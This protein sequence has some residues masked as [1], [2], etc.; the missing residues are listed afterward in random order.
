MW[1]TLNSYT[2]TIKFTNSIPNY[3]LKSMKRII[4][5]KNTIQWKVQILLHYQYMLQK[6]QNSSSLPNYVLEVCVC[7]CVFFTGVRTCARTRVSVVLCWGRKGA[8]AWAG[9]W[10]SS[11]FERGEK[12]S[13]NVSSNLVFFAKFLFEGATMKK[14]C[15]SWGVLGIS[16]TSPSLRAS[17]PFSREAPFQNA[18]SPGMTSS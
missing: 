18:A 16:L 9:D 4:S 1:P 11:L 15:G 6:L 10:C 8:L 2:S 14:G 13:I 17:F 7:V 5:F 12:T 3:L